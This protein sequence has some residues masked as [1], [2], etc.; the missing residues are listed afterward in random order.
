MTMDLLHRSFIT[1]LDRDEIQ[2]LISKMDDIMDYVD[3]TAKTISIFD[4][5]ALPAQLKK[6]IEILS[7]SQAKVEE[8][9]KL[10]PAFKYE[11]EL[12]TS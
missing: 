5:A 4:F 6:M 1:P 2:K 12:S 3:R 10:I 9:V 7:W 8:A 11:E